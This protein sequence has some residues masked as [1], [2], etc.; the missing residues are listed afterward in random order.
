MTEYSTAS[1]DTGRF[2]KNGVPQ[3]DQSRGPDLTASNEL[4]SFAKGLEGLAASGQNMAIAQ[5]NQEARAEKEK[6]AKEIYARQEKTQKENEAKARAELLWNKHGGT[7]NDLTEK[8]KAEAQAGISSEGVVQKRNVLSEK[9]KSDEYLKEAYQLKRYDS[10]LVKHQV[11]WNKTSPHIVNELYDE[12]LLQKNTEGGSQD[13]LEYGTTRLEDIKIDRFQKHYQGL[14]PKILGKALNAR[15]PSDEIFLSSLADKQDGYINE[16]QDRNIQAGIDNNKKYKLDTPEGLDALR[17][18]IYLADDGTNKMKVYDRDRVTRQLI[19]HLDRE[20][21]AAT[22]PNDKVFETIKAFRG[23]NSKKGKAF[24]DRTGVGK[25]WREWVTKAVKKK[26]TLQKAKTTADTA[27]LTQQI[28]TSKINANSLQIV[29]ASALNYKRPSPEQ[30]QKAHTSGTTPPLERIEVLQ[31]ALRNLKKGEITY[32]Y[33]AKGDKAAD[34]TKL[35][36]DLEDAIQKESTDHE[37][38]KPGIEEKAKATNEFKA[39][40]VDMSKSQIEELR[41]TLAKTPVPK[42]LGDLRENLMDERETE[43]KESQTEEKNALAILTSKDN[44][45]EKRKTKSSETEKNRI[46]QEL[47]LGKETSLGGKKFHEPRTKAEM[48]QLLQG[49][50]SNKKLTQGDITKLTDE[51]K[52]LIKNLE[53]KDREIDDGKKFA[54]YFKDLTTFEE[55]SGGYPSV[56]DIENL[57]TKINS[58]TWTDKAKH[59]QLITLLAAHKKGKEAYKTARDEIK[60][61]NKYSTEMKKK[62]S[63]VKTQLLELASKV[64]TKELTGEEAEKEYKTLKKAFEDTNAEFI[65]TGVDLKNKIDYIDVL[66]KGL[67][68]ILSQRTEVDIAKAKKKLVKAAKLNVEQRNDKRSVILESH[69]KILN[70]KNLLLDPKQVSELSKQIRQ[71]SFTEVSDDGNKT[72]TNLFKAEEAEKFIRQLQAEV[73]IAHDPSKVVSDAD[74]L[75]KSSQNIKD[76]RELSGTERINK[77]ADAR[78]YLM[79]NLI[80]RKLSITEYRNELSTLNSIESSGKTETIKPFRAGE[81]AIRMV[82]AGKLEKYLNNKRYLPAREGTKLL[83][84]ITQEFHRQ[85]NSN[86]SELEGATEEQQLAKAY[87]IANSLTKV[88]PN[89]DSHPMKGMNERLMLFGMDRKQLKKAGV[90]RGGIIINR[91][92]FNEATGKTSTAKNPTT[93]KKDTRLK[94]DSDFEKALKESYEDAED[95]Q[96]SQEVDNSSNIYGPISSLN[97]PIYGKY[98]FY[99]QTT[100][101][102]YY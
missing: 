40:V 28:K 6:R 84:E 19:Q 48:K 22:D 64:A 24:F 68:G 55:T 67:E 76:I 74:V 34:F 10:L 21:E 13:F 83:N 14:D 29:G 66:D 46:K 81:E 63:P 2:D 17:D 41:S 32:G 33:F 16:L 72:V 87:E 57:E 85:W 54:T 79:D 88:Y 99:R 12:W 52:P 96:S 26:N 77:I 43:I 69:T 8:E 100:E 38:Y 51:I 49:L 60:K 56:K 11:N 62:L 4:M 7:W 42:W 3:L 71:S 47:I 59:G 30:I 93:T 61:E 50:S 90:G 5:K 101:L 89:N 35:E 1:F 25:K 91:E 39:Q 98:D 23:K 58:R 73:L 45:K 65:A 97:V 75:I 44:L 78:Y 18:E 95:N 94:P 102:L 92:K 37:D 9:E 80:D 20:V 53:T 27:F 82:F 86:G 31:H 70:D 15:K 36:K